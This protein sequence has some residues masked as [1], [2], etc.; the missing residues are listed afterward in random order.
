MKKIDVI[1][2]FGSVAKTAR[3]LRI[4]E[5]TV[6]RWGEEL[7]DKTAFKVELVT[8]GKFLTE[9]SQRGKQ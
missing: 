1:N 4:N 5:S 7:S 3:A 6:Y 8:K 2:Y 9:E